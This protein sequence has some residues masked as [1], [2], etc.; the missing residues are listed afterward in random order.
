[1]A[2]DGDAGSPSGEVAKR[3]GRRSGSPGPARASLIVKGLVYAPDHGVA[4]LTVPGMAD[5]IQ[6]QAID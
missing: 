6:R 2:R 5:F 3:L 1:M 4:A